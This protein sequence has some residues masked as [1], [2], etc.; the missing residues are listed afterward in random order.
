MF[1]IC[2][3]LAAC[4]G[5]TSAP[6]A[7]SPAADAEPEPSLLTGTEGD[8]LAGD[9]SEADTPGNGIAAEGE[10]AIEGYGALPPATV[11]ALPQEQDAP[12]GGTRTATARATLYVSPNGVDTNAGSAS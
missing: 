6:V 12:D 11:A 4:G 2:L 9:E 5:G 10:F 8:A 1:I 7:P 3:T